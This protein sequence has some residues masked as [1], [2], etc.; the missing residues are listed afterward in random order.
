MFDD[1][2]KSEIKIVSSTGDIRGTTKAVVTADLAVIDDEKAIISPDDEIRRTLPNGQEETFRVVDPVFYE[3]M[4][5]IPAHYQ[6]K[7]VR[8][9][10]FAPRTGGN[11]NVHVSGENARVNIG[12]L[13]QSNNVVTT[14]STFNQLRDAIT[15]E[16][17]DAKA[18]DDLLKL[19]AQMEKEQSKPGFG[20]AYQKF[21]AAAGDHMKIIGPFI[22]LLAKFF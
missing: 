18:S 9:G 7:I 20:S 12:S 6:V 1:F 22:P 16:G 19:I 10:T 3:A 4:H 13:D 14:S 11:Y 17:L 2:P 8:K 15:T 21:I 5:G